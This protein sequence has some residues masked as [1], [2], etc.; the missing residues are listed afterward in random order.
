MSKR[1]CI[2]FM[3]AAIVVVSGAFVLAA[4]D[5]VMAALQQRFKDRYEALLKLKT[6]GKIG[7][8]WEGYLEAVKAE[9]LNDEQV[10]SI[11]SAE[12][13]DR[14]ELYKLIAEKQGTKPEVVAERNALREMKK[15]RPGEYVKN[16][17]TGWQQVQ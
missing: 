3:V 1:I 2:P 10:K 15:A 16:K 11:L 17:D 5:E 9:Y 13:A 12:N 4:G 14:R 6:D 8:T 7:E